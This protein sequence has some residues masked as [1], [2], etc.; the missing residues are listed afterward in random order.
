MTRCAGHDAELRQILACAVL[1]DTAEPGEAEALDLLSEI[2]G[3]G[4]RSR[5]YQ[6]LVVKSGLA[7][8]SRRLL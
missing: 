7:S 6:Q 3:G 5:I 1:S 2:L 4:T 8:G